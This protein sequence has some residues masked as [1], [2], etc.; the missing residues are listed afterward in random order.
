[1]HLNIVEYSIPS[2]SQSDWLRGRTEAANFAL[3]QS[4][5]YYALAAC[6]ALGIHLVNTEFLL[7][8]AMYR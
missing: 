1:M 7:K 2:C 5:I 6:Y 3:S 4:F 8:D